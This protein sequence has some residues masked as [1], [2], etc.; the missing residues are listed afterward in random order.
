MPGHYGSVH[1]H[2]NKS[3]TTGGGSTNRERG[4]QRNQTQKVSKKTKTGGDDHRTTRNSQTHFINTKMPPMEKSVLDNTLFAKVGSAIASGL[5]S[6]T[7]ASVK[8]RAFFDKNYDRIRANKT[9]IG[10]PDKATFDALPLSEKQAL[11]RATR[12]DIMRN[13][14]NPLGEPLGDD[15]RGGANQTLLS[16]EPT[17]GVVTN[18]GIVGPIVGSNAVKSAEEIQAEKNK[19]GGI[20]LAKKRG[21]S[22][23]I[24]TSSQGLMDDEDIIMRKT[25]L[26]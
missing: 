9:N 1:S 3:T 18:D 20:I 5:D 16:Q 14:Q 13:R 15:G 24:K 12:L 25:L 19:E 8:N 22:E 4:I 10:L 7:N 6:V 21:R 11:Y 17:S 2:S 23:M 26:G